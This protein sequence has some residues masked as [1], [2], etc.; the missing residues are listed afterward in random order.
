MNCVITVD[1]A[2]WFLVFFEL[3]SLT[4]YFL[5]IT[6]QNEASIKG[7]FMYFVMAHV[8]FF[9]IMV[10]FLTMAGMTGSFDFAVFR[11]T[12]FAPG[13]ASLCFVL[14]FFGF[15]FKAGMIPFHSW[16]PM[17]HPAAPSNVSAFM[18]GG[19]IKIGKIGRA[20]V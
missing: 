8:G 11:A 9:M 14:A 4:S 16:L 19:M 10:S 5:V 1:N 6:E 17:A 3:M 13:I 2:F 7:G 18:S 12:E 20:H 15:G